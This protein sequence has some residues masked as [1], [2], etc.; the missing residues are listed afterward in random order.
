MAAAGELHP[1]EAGARRAWAGGQWSP[2]QG[3]AASG[4][5]NWL[6]A[7]MRQLRPVLRAD[8][9]AILLMRLCADE[10]LA[11]A[12]GSRQRPLTPGEIR[13]NWEE[14]GLRE[15]LLIR[16]GLRAEDSVTR[17]D[18]ARSAWRVDA[19]DQWL[20][21]NRFQ[22][23]A[24]DAVRSVRMQDSETEGGKEEAPVAIYVLIDAD[25]TVARA[26]LD[27]M[28]L[29]DVCVLETA[30]AA[31]GGAAS[32]TT[33]LLELR[34]EHSDARVALVES[35]VDRLRAAANAPALFSCELYFA[36]WGSSTPEQQAS[37]A[38]MPR[39]RD[40]GRQSGSL[41]RALRGAAAS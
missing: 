33:E 22:S 38:S 10:A 29:G 21:S 40:L 13:A 1:R 41:R 34:Q 6:A 4:V 27:K 9:D 28:G 19:P 32:P 15:T 18:E 30:R 3:I 20:E 36:P 5:P 17:F 2:L 12:R 11:A 25:D 8:S 16:Y 24:V 37:A 14:L 35:D 39:V 31:S 26:L 23:G 7:K